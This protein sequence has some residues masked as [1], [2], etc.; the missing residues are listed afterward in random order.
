MVLRAIVALVVLVSA[1]RILTFGL[2]EYYLEAALDG[3]AEAVD[4]ALSWQ[5]KHP[6]AL[7]LKAKQVAEKDPSL[8]VSL[9]QK[10][11][12]YNPTDGRAVAELALLLLEKG[13]Q[14]RGDVLAEQAVKLMPSYVPVRLKVAQYWVRQERW[15][16]ALQNWDAALI[17]QPTMGDKI[18][19][20]LLQ[21]A[22]AE[23]SRAYLAD[24]TADPPTWWDKFYSHVA[25]KSTSLDTVIALASMRQASSAKLSETERKE[26]VWRLMEEKMWPEAYLVWA[27]GL[28]TQQKKYLGSVYNGGFELESTDDGFDWR[29]PKLKGVSVLRQSQA[30]ATGDEALHIQFEN[31]EMR[32]RHLY[33]P[34]FLQKG[35]HEFLV[36]TKIDF[37]RGRG[38]LIWTVRCAGNEKELL[39][40]SEKLLGAGDWETVSFKFAV[41]EGEQCLGQILR[42][43]STGKHTYD[44][45]LEGDIWFDQ[46]IIRSIRQ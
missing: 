30:G 5:D 17:T 40:E 11:I 35:T 24:F 34:L 29:L 1:W 28:S 42:L 44:H 36:K 39:G 33:Q 3:D 43:E 37:L 20:V 9:L 16:K 13:E 25:R 27:N 6:K 18:F 38:G 41:P 46:V 8:A 14:A 31:K 45:K 19:P 7:Y 12:G 23:G 15:D 4:K 10:S 22:D 26:L 2:A 21:L 32:F